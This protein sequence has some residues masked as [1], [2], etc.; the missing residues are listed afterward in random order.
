MSIVASPTADG[1]SE[2]LQALNVRSSVF[3]LSDLR[4]PW[5][6]RVGGADVAKFH[7]VLAGAAWVTLQGRDPMRVEAGD[8]I[9]LPHGQ[10]HTISDEPGSPVVALEE[11]LADYAP[12]EAPRLRFG[13]SGAQTRLL[14]GGFSVAAGLQDVTLAAL[15]DIVHMPST[16]VPLAM[17]LEPFLAMLNAEADERQPGSNAIVTKIADVFLTQALRTWLVGAAQAGL[18]VTGH[19]RDQPIEQAIRVIHSDPAEPWTLDRLAAQVGLA[20]TS[21]ALRFR[22]L[23]GEPPMQYLTKVRLA[24]AAGY[25]STSQLTIYEIAQLTGYHDLAAFSKAFKREFGRAPGA[26]RRAAGQAPAVSIA[27]AY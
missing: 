20:R 6:F 25:L 4:A 7:L 12:A 15:P 27:Q 23:V 18:L 16:R 22:Q 2:A 8:L 21:L 3:C 14:C 26:Y 24:R 19:V 17:W 1:V 13:G 9:V 11:I 5:A 10:S